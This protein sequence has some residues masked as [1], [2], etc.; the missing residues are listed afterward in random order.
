MQIGK[1]PPQ[2][3]HINVA[4][5][6]PEARQ[7]HGYLESK[8]RALAFTQIPHG[9]QRSFAIQFRVSVL[10]SSTKDEVVEFERSGY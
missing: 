3:R 6:I 8:D 7:R 9:R 5:Q 10:H 4:K 2:L 1:S